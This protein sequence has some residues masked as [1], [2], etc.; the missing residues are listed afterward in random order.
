[1]KILDQ[2][3]GG[4]YLWAVALLSFFVIVASYTLHTFP[5]ALV[6]GVMAAALIEILI[7]KFYLKHKFK[8]PFSGIITGLIIGSVAPINASLFLIAIAVM[9]AI[10]SK[11]FI[12]FKGSNIFNPASLGLIIALAIFGVGDEWWVA[13]NYNIYGIAISLTPLLVILAYEAR[14]LTSAFSFVVVIL[15]LDLILGN[16]L[17]SISLST[18]AALLFS[19]NYYF[20]F[21]MLIEPKTSPHNKYAQIVYGGL[22]ALL[23]LGFILYRMPYSLLAALLLANFSYLI[24]RKYW[25][26]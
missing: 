2:P 9:I 16:Y 24:Y 18:F 3:V 25:K 22:T 19:V 15:V 20:A 5:L 8:I 4:M 23:Y 11:F 14:R 21:V 17:H 1:M 6:F 26:R 13:S 10:I 12:Q 7:R